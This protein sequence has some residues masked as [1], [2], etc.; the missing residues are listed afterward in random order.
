[1]MWYTN[2]WLGPDHRGDAPAAREGVP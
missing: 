1:V 2:G